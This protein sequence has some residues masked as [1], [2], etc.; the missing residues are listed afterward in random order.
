MGVS[1]IVRCGDDVSFCALYPLS[2]DVQMYGPVHGTIGDIL[3]A[4]IL[5]PITGFFSLAARSRV[6]R[7][8]FTLTTVLALAGIQR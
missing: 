4:Q 7:V 6:T 3:P 1:Q 5:A 8:S 2:P